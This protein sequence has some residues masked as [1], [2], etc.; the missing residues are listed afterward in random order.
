MRYA[1]ANAYRLLLPWLGRS[2][3]LPTNSGQQQP[4]ITLTYRSAPLMHNRNPR[5]DRL[6]STTR[7][8]Q[9]KYITPF[10]L[11]NT[12]CIGMALG[13]GSLLLF[14]QAGVACMTSVLTVTL[15]KQG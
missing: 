11:D 15:L 12:F 4:S 10:K 6:T 5:N 8:I 14:R 2:Q 9:P 1:V 7:H 3:L 13:L